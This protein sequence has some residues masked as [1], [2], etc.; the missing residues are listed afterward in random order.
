[1]LSKDKVEI[2]HPKRK[3]LN[4]PANNLPGS[5]ASKPQWDS[6]IMKAAK[7]TAWR[8]AV[9]RAGSEDRLLHNSDW[10]AV[11]IT[12]RSV[13]DAVR[14]RVPEF[15]QE[16][17][18]QGRKLCRDSYKGGQILNRLFHMYR[19]RREGGGYDVMF[20]VEHPNNSKKLRDFAPY[21]INLYDRGEVLRGKKLE[22]FFGETK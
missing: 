3:N 8:F 10:K 12:A 5:T 6:P 7:L 18:R 20:T 4:G 16:W 2:K 21:F 15:D 13:L 14:S 9:D 22:Q 17:E 11:G 19:R 1:M